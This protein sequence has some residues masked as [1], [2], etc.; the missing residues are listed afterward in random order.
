MFSR[1]FS[2]NFL[3]EV[4]MFRPRRRLKMIEHLDKG[5]HVMRSLRV[6]PFWLRNSKTNNYIELYFKKLL[7]AWDCPLSS[8]I[9]VHIQFII[10]SESFSSLKPTSEMR[11]CR[12][13]NS[14]CA[15]NATYSC[16]HLLCSMFM[17]R[18]PLGQCLLHHKNSSIKYEATKSGTQQNNHKVAWW[19]TVDS[20]WSIWRR[21]G[22]AAVD[23]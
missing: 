6:H 19:K 22:L 3:W 4:N 16:F 9:E 8:V 20:T 14:L 18:R 12:R 7:M 21:F 5:Q 1:K 23:S 11:I 10:S 17:S 13:G 15:F 2:F